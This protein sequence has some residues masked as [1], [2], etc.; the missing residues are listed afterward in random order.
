MKKYLLAG[1]MALCVLSGCSGK[2]VRNEKTAKELA[3]EGTKRYE[4]GNYMGAVESFE[5]LKEW[6]PFSDLS[7]LAE[8]KIA[9][10]YYHMEKYAEASQW[11]L[12]FENLHPNNEVIP[13]VIYQT[14]RCSFD[15]LE[16][17]DQDPSFGRKA[18]SI[19]SRLIR[20]YPDDPHALRAAHHIDEC[21]KKLAGNEFYIGMFYYKDKNYKAALERFKNVISNYPDVGIN[22]KALQYITLCE[23]KIQLQAENQVDPED[24]SENTF[25]ASHV[26]DSGY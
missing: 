8:L 24:A 23:D 16:K 18:L 14:G 4:D 6:Y 15:Q 9:D 13:Y 20:E 1:L 2:E 26:S 25:D 10:A 11:Y 22:G 17:I 3:E 7:I 5:K 21:Y 19:F 12:E